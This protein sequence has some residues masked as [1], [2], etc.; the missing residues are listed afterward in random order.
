MIAT[1]RTPNGKKPRGTPPSIPFYLI[2]KHSRGRAIIALP[3]R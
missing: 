3:S 1:R 2:K